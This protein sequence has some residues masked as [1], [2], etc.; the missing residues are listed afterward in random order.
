MALDGLMFD[1]LIFLPF[2]FMVI[3][4]RAKASVCP[5]ISYDVAMNEVVKGGISEF[6]GLGH[7]KNWIM[8]CELRQDWFKFFDN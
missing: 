6:I 2:Y 4:V 7:M 3:C 8:L 1:H 5:H